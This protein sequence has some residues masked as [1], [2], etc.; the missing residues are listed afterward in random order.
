MEDIASGFGKVFPLDLLVTMSQTEREKKHKTEVFR[1]T[2]A[3][4]RLGPSNETIFIVPNFAKMQ[5]VDYDEKEADRQELIPTKVKKKQPT[6]L[7]TW[8]P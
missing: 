5:F 8:G 2:I 7:G 3:K 4:S 1:L 6:K